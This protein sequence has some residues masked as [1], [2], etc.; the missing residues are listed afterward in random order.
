MTTT[1]IAIGILA[2]VGLAVVAFLVVNANRKR[3]S[4]EDVPPAMRPGYSD[5]QLERTVLER[6]MGWGLVL[7]TGLAV[8]VP[9]YFLN[10]RNRLQEARENFFVQAVVRGE[11]E[12]VANCAECHSENLAGGGAPSPYDP[13]SSW[14]APAL[15]DIATRYAE[16]ENVV[17]VRDFIVQTLQR[18]RPGTPM[19]TWGSA[20]GGPMTDQQIEDIADY[21]LAN[22]VAATAAGG[23]GASEAEG[24]GDEGGEDEG[25]SNAGS[26]AGTVEDG[27]E[28]PEDAASEDAEGDGTAPVEGD[29]AETSETDTAGTSE[30]DTAQTVSTT[31][32]EELYSANCTKCHGADLQGIVGPSLIGVL[33]R[34][35]REDVLGILQNGIYIPT[36]A[37]MP[38]FGT[39]NYQYEGASYDDEA[40]ERIIDYLEEAQPAELG[41]DALLYQTP[42]EGQAEAADAAAEAP[43]DS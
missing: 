6:Y 28:E 29:T 37:V 3:R 32:G 34:H 31:D 4:F 25:T 12:Y 36:G 27:A 15:D 33:E 21:I 30:G 16:S 8:F 9:V 10:E 38:A 35:S 7:T 39:Q 41:E 42:G 5:E 24:A 13:E 14:P 23:E 40:L 19:P 26:T 22:Q 2:L 1:A 17:D 11:E 20:Y 18:G 43:A